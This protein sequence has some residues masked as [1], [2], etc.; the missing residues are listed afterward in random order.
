ML[1][2]RGS[3]A[4][5]FWLYHGRLAMV[6]CMLASTAYHA[7][8]QYGRKLLHTH[9]QCI[10]TH[11][12]TYGT[13]RHYIPCPRLLVE[14]TKYTQNVMMNAKPHDTLLSHFVALLHHLKAHNNSS[15]HRPLHLPRRVRNWNNF[16]WMPF[17]MPPMTNTDICW[18]R[19]RVSRLRVYCFNYR[20][21]AIPTPYISVSV[22]CSTDNS[23]A[24]TSEDVIKLLM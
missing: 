16:S 10:Y 9:I 18:N 4:A 3:P 20:A 24:S 21:K 15:L 1:K 6:W 2:E 12:R 5:S 8:V 7:G 23:N 11:R 17:L 14:I 19:C 13:A 22:T